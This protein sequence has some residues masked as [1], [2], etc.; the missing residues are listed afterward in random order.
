MPKKDKITSVFGGGLS[1]SSGPSSVA[2]GPDPSEGHLKGYGNSPTLS[3][4]RDGSASPDG[5]KGSHP[6]SYGTS[7]ADGTFVKDHIQRS[8]KGSGDRQG[9]GSASTTGTLGA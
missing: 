5:S 7:Q 8:V 1:M 6:S 2:D 3:P 9:A 4:L